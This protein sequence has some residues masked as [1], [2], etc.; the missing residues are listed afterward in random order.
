MKVYYRPGHDWLERDE[1]FAKKVL[2]NPKSHWVMDTKHDVLCVVKLGNHISAVRFLA[3]HFYGLDRIYREDIPKWQEIISKNM[4]FYNA[5]V[6]E[7][8]HYARHL[9]RK[10]RGI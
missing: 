10:Y 7:A 3:K 1:E 9:P 4:I 5:M 2:N 8:D 6:N